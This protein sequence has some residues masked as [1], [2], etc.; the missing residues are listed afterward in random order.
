MR[1]SGAT[2]PV[3]RTGSGAAHRHNHDEHERDGQRHPGHGERGHQQPHRQGQRNRQP[4][5][6]PAERDERQQQQGVPGVARAENQEGAADHHELT[7]P[8]PVGVGLPDGERGQTGQQE[9]GH[10]DGRAAR[11]D[12]RDQGEPG[13][14]LVALLGEVAGQVAEHADAGGQHVRHVEQREGHHGGENDLP[15]LSLEHRRCRDGRDEF[16]TDGH[17]QQDPA[18]KVLFAA[19]PEGGGK[20]ERHPEQVDVRVGDALRRDQRAPRPEG[21]VPLVDAAA[22]HAHQQHP[23]DADTEEQAGQLQRPVPRL[24]ADDGPD[25]DE[26]DLGGRRIDRGDGRTIQRRTQGQG[27]VPVDGLDAFAHTGRPV[28]T[29]NRGGEQPVRPQP[30]QPFVRRHVGVRRDPGVLHDAVPGVPGGIGAGIRRAGH[31]GPTDEDGAGQHEHHDGPALHCAQDE[32]GQ[33]RRGSRGPRCPEPAGRC[34]VRP[35]Q[36]E[37]Q[38]EHRGEGGVGGQEDR[39]DGYTHPAIL[40]E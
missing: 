24:G 12:Q 15:A 33:R 31:R 5:P 26:V 19:D 29:G 7:E 1:V 21:G 4:F 10:D 27:R 14:V 23:G 11:R 13:A 20:D 16:D 30:V 17:A 37:G 35:E 36:V 32:H 6:A 38:H 22:A 40:P 39:D 18:A 25:G 2:P 34:R 9:S 8:G 3:Q 28:L